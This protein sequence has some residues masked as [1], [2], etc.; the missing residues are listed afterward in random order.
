MYSDTCWSNC[1][2]IPQWSTNSIS[3]VDQGTS[4]IVV[5]VVAISTCKPQEQL[6]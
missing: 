2:G 1:G 4:K 3:Y 5:C 6:S